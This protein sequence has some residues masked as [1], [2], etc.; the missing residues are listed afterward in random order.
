LYLAFLLLYT[1]SRKWRFLGSITDNANALSLCVAFATFLTIYFEIG[2]LHGPSIVQRFS[3]DS[4]SGAPL[5]ASSNADIA[6]LLVEAAV[7]A[8]SAAAFYSV[9]RQTKRSGSV[10]KTNPFLP[11]AILSTLI[12]L[13]L[14]P[15]CFG[16]IVMPPDSFD[17]VEL[18]VKNQ[19]AKSGLLIFVGDNSYF[20]Y[21][22]NREL[23]Q[24]H[25][26]HVSQ[27]LYELNRKTTDAKP[28]P[29]K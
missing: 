2:L 6:L 4:A 20:L 5:A 13:L 18:S 10:L 19:P 22:E 26:E 29:G 12:M 8:I 1:L 21:T 23:L 9:Q 17:S 16:R 3:T 24:I 28:T 11:L 27:I 14:L 7:V 25:K 15:A